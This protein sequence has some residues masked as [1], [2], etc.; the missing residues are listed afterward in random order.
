MTDIGPYGKVSFNDNSNIRNEG[1]VVVIT[2]G[3][4]S[5]VGSELV[6]GTGQVS[7]DSVKLATEDYVDQAVLGG[8]SGGGATELYVDTKVAQ[9]DSKVTALTTR[10]STLEANAGSG[11][12]SY[13]PGAFTNVSSFG[14]GWANSAGLGAQPQAPAGYRKTGTDVELRGTVGGTGASAIIFIL[15]SGF[16]PQYQVTIPV[17]GTEAFAVVKINPNGQV[18]FTAPNSNATMVSLH[19]VRFSLLA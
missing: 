18:L 10:V 3:T 13:N 12:G 14:A 19:G 8:S 9:V 15:P 7:L 17:S 2:A 11:S 5:S 4:D 6:I 1:G 16:R